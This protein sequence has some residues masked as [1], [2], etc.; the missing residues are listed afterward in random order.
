MVAALVPFLQ[1]DDAELR[2]DTAY[3]LRGF[4]SRALQSAA[5]ALLAALADDSAWRVRAN[6]AYALMAIPQSAGTLAAFGK[7]AAD[8]DE[9]VPAAFPKG[10]GTIGKAQPDDDRHVMAF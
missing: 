7:C 4:Y 9:R 3:V 2:V 1:S 5:P 8:R 6:A 10:R